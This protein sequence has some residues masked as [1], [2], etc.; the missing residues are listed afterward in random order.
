MKS[1]AG[2]LALSLV[3]LTSACAVTSEEPGADEGAVSSE[4]AITERVAPNSELVTTTRVKLREGPST[5]RDV[6][7]VLDMG[8]TVTVVTGKPTNGFY[9]VERDG[10]QGWVFGTYLR[11]SGD[12]GEAPEE[13]APPSGVSCVDASAAS[14]MV[15]KARR[16]DGR[17]SQHLC[18]RYVKDHIEA[19]GV[20]SRSVIPAAYQASAYQFATWGKRDPAALR[21]A[22][23]AKLSVNL[24]SVPSGAVLVWRAGQCGYSAQHGHIEIAIGGGRACSDFCGTIKKGCGMPDVF[25][26]IKDGCQ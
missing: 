12:K 4:A 23:F 2:V 16:M 13:G 17:G 25:V 6:I 24:A 8:E 7:T 11:P 21:A 1:R 22:G 18:Y 10:E 15:A 14:R 19:A 26:P 3:T 9:E 5:S 20:M